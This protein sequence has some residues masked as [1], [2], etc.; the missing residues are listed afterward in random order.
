MGQVKEVRDIEL[1]GVELAIQE[2]DVPVSAHKAVDDK[3]AKT[4]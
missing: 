1:M 2:D 4:P 3:L